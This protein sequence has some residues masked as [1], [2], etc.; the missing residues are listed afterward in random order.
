MFQADYNSAS[1]HNLEVVATDT[2][3]NIGITGVVVS[4]SPINNDPPILDLNIT[5]DNSNNALKPIL[6]VEKSG[7]PV[8]LLTEPDITDPDLVQ[9]VIKEIKVSIAN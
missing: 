7:S 9:L 6:F 4:V 5:D 3:N 8:T 2:N 1:V